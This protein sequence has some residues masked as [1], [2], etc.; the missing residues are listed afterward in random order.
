MYFVVI[1]DIEDEADYWF[2]VKKNTNNKEESIAA[3]KIYSLFSP[4][5]QQLKYYFCIR[6]KS[7]E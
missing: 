3:G 2:V 6:V 4:V 5:T 1:L 7:F